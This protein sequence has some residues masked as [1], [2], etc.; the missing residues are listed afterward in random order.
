MKQII[1]LFFSVISTI[2]AQQIVVD[3]PEFEKT[4]LI[5]TLGEMITFKTNFVDVKGYQNKELV[6]IDGDFTDSYIYID[7]NFTTININEG[8]NRLKYL[9]R[10]DSIQKEDYSYV[11]SDTAFISIYITYYFTTDDNSKLEFSIYNNKFPSGI[12]V[13]NETYNISYY[14]INEEY[15]D[16][17][18]SIIEHNRILLNER[19][20]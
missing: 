10:L 9:V 15:S 6:E 17:T 5:D 8:G 16:E 18:L 2:T 4:I 1:F 7:T 11:V 3:A 19:K 20:K 14:W 12:S 13:I